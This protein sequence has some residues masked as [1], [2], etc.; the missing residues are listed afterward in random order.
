M[1]IE[2]GPRSWYQAD[3]FNEHLRLMGKCRTEDDIRDKSLFME[4]NSLERRARIK[5]NKVTAGKKGF[6]RH[7]KP[8]DKENVKRKRQQRFHQITPE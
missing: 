4:L 7:R 6:P 1:A 2:R 3:L 8:G 5:I